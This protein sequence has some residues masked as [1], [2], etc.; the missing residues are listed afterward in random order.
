LFEQGT[1][2]NQMINKGLSTPYGAI[3]EPNVGVFESYLVY[4]PGNANENINFS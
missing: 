3:F 2:E 1:L 4:I